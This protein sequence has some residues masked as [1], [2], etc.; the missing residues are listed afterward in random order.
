M[1]L[2]TILSTISCTLSGE[3]HGRIKENGNEKIVISDVEHNCKP[4]LSGKLNGKEKTI[5]SHKLEYKM[6]ENMLYITLPEI[7]KDAEDLQVTLSSDDGEITISIPNEA[8]QNPELPVH[9]QS[10]KE[11]SSSKSSSSSKDGKD[12]EKTKDKESSSTDKNKDNGIASFGIPIFGV[13]LAY[14]FI[15]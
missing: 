12:K 7:L 9:G 11:K 4:E 6:Q 10:A 8:P 5:K 3:Y 15:F 14:F 13:L 1:Y 2:L